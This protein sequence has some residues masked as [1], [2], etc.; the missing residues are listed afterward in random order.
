M[1]K[2]IATTLESDTDFTVFLSIIKLS[3]LYSLLDGDDKY[4]LFAPNNEAFEN[5]TAPVYAR[6]INEDRKKLRRIMEY[7]IIPG[8]YKL[9]DLTHNSKLQ[10]LNGNDVN[11]TTVNEDQTRINESSIIRP[12][13]LASNGVIH[14]VNAVL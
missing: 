14:M 1:R 8:E 12:N 10:T 2:S 9:D 13:K 7:H 5:L 6:L 11:I 3:G 4:T